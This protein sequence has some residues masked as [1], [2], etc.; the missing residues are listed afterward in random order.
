MARET[1]ESQKRCQQIN[2]INLVHLNDFVITQIHILDIS[3]I[4]AMHAVVFQLR[5]PFVPRTLID[6][7]WMSNEKKN[8]GSCRFW[9]KPALLA[10]IVQWCIGQ[11]TRCVI[12]WCAVRT[13]LTCFGIRVTFRIYR[14]WMVNFDRSIRS[15]SV[16]VSSW[17]A[18]HSTQNSIHLSLPR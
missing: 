2:Q 3:I 8:S 10:A 6:R 9:L 5:H 18:Q 7:Q 11:M 15:H 16:F 17:C 13:I 12:Q 14:M 1:K 4:T